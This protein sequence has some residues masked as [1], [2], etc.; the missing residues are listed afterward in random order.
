MPS[1]TGYSPRLTTPEPTAQWWNYDFAQG[2]LLIGNSPESQTYNCVLPNCFSGDTEIMTDL[3]NVCLRDAVNT[4]PNILTIDGIYRKAQICEFG[5]QELWSVTFNNGH[6][7]RASA[8]HRWL[9]YNLA[10]AEDYQIITTECLCEGMSVKLVATEEF[11][12]IANVYNTHE[13]ATVYCPVEP[14]THTCVLSGGELTGQCVG[15]AW[16]RF[17]EIMN[18]FPDALP[19][20]NAGDWYDESQ[21]YQKTTDPYQPR[22]GAVIVWKPNHVG[23]VEEIERDATGKVI[24]ITTSESGWSSRVGWSNRFWTTK[25]YPPNYDDYSGY[26]FVGFIYNPAVSGDAVSI[27]DITSP[28]HPA[29]KFVAEAESHVGTGGHAWVQSMTNIGNQAWCAATCCAVA[30]ACGYAGVIMPGD[31]YVAPSFGEQIVK[32]YGGTRIDGPMCGNS[33][34]VPQ[35]GDLIIYQNP[36]DPYWDGQHIGI[37]RYC[38][39]D[40]VYTVE[41]NTGNSEYK[42]R[43]KNR[44]G[45]GIGWYARPDWTKVGGT[46]TIGTGTASYIRRDLYD[47][48]NDRLD[49]SIRE[50]CYMT[51]D[52]KPS[53]SLTSVKLSVINYTSM[54]QVLVRLLGGVVEAVPDGYLGSPDN[55][56]GLDPIPREIV[57]FL[58]SKGL[59]TAAAIGVI[60]NIRAE[61]SFRTDAVGDYGTSF[62]LC[63]WHNERNT[64]MRQVAGTNWST[65][66][67]GQLEYLWIE[68]NQS[69]YIDLLHTLQSVPN[70]LEGAKTAT[71]AFIRN[72]EFP[73]EVNRKSIERQG[74]AE[75]YWNQVVV[76][77]SNAGPTGV[78]ASAQEV[79]TK[80]SGVKV[81]QGTAV[82][83][84]DSVPQTGIIANYTSYTE[85]FNE[86]VGVQRKL[87]DIWASQGRPNTYS[88]A[89]ISGYYLIAL[90]PVFGDVGDVVS[91]VFKDGTYFN[92]IIADAKGGDSP[93]EWGHYFG[94]QVD[95]VEWEAYGHDQNVL[96]KGL[97][98]AGWLDK[99]I[100]RIVNYGSWLS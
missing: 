47:T 60:A 71:D 63:Q 16:G 69:Y 34:A 35:A 75:E 20:G 87:A 32:K 67:T 68:L 23:I 93:S 1:N 31:D 96:R 80:Q 41:G 10:D 88:V 90:K 95:V 56:D 17:A 18:G 89:T 3:G 91:V 92:A 48:E 94:N 70:T 98:D 12:E 72:F 59:N 28:E 38:E 24:S 9:I 11:V 86:W 62:G 61:S 51:Y 74:Y 29:R 64:A 42:F 22:L 54:L 81:T 30:K 5:L 77:N 85:Y 52:C 76:V 25:R 66:L 46:A 83:I 97:Q 84:P 43:E 2:R 57:E 53:I 33:D 44:T 36:G 8:N 19:T 26:T 49:A 73:A 37:V 27:V 55:I 14:I 65:N 79:I 40:I 78:S 99:K 45:S 7:Y 4:S 82:S 15:Y 39:G 50:V 6:T 58:L 21:V 13:F 100:D